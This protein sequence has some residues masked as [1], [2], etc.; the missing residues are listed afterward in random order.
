MTSKDIAQIESKLDS[1]N[2]SLIE[3]KATF[4]E[5]FKHILTKEYVKD[6]ITKQVK[7]LQSDCPARKSYSSSDRIKMITNS[8]I[9]PDWIKIIKIIG[10]VSV[11]I[12]SAI[13]GHQ[14]GVN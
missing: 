8:A 11:P 14:I 13:T 12:I 5:K 1:V 3:F 2:E 10:I 9:T 7:M 6:E 4:T